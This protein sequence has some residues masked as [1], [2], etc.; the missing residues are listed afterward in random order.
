MDCGPLV[1]CEEYPTVV[2]CVDLVVLSWFTMIRHIFRAI[3]CVS[4]A[5]I[6]FLRLGHKT[7]EMCCSLITKDSKSSL[8]TGSLWQCP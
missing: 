5:C 7:G 8:S 2:L 4:V 6:Y 1:L 3:L